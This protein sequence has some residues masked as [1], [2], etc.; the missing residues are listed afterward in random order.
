[1]VMMDENITTSEVWHQQL[2]RHSL[3]TFDS[4]LRVLFCF[5]DT[6]HEVAEIIQAN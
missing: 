4:I 5:K 2:Q 6:Q 3:W 1:M